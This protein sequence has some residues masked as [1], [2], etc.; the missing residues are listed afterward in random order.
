MLESIPLTRPVKGIKLNPLTIPV[1]LSNENMG[2]T[3]PHSFKQLYLNTRFTKSPVLKV[4]W[5]SKP[6]SNCLVTKIEPL[7]SLF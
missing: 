7:V 4:T 2:S 1:P 5:L 6:V 3:S